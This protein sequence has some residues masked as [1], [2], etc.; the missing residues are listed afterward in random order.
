MLQ[1]AE[2]QVLEAHS[3]SAGLDYPGVGP[4]HSQFKDAGLA[5]YESVTDEEAVAAMDLMSR[6][7]GIIPALEPSHALAWVWRER[8]TLAGKTVVLC[9]SGRG[10]K[11][12]DQI[13]EASAR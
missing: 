6:T 9:L 12:V 4:E 3:I 11:D 8:A 1:D 10:D 13:A 5:R 2:G 7:E